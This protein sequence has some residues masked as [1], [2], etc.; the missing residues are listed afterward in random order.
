M[1]TAALDR[2][3]TANALQRRRWEN[4]YFCPLCMRSLE[5]PTHLLTECPW[6]KEIWST[7]AAWSQSPAIA[8]ETCNGAD[9][10][11]EWLK[12]C[13]NR[14]PSDKRKGTQSLILLASWEIWCE[15][16]RRIFQK[17]ELS[18]QALM[19]RIRE[20]ATLW[21]VAGATIPFDPG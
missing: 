4:N 10:I 1:W 17:V 21:N 6:T 3:L 12:G 8:P 18:A 9:S 13:R 7:L 20:E 11:T 5:T 19:S 16:N 14:S 15:R 2:I